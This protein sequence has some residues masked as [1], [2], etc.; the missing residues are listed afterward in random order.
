M[1]SRSHERRFLR[2]AVD[3]IWLERYAFVVLNKIDVRRL[4]AR[5]E[6]DRAPRVSAARR[7]AASMHKPCRLLWNVVLYDPVDVHNIQSARHH[8]GAHENCAFCPSKSFD[9]QASAQATIRHKT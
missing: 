5:E 9:L 4:F 3:G 6:D 2:E 1:R 8:I 7:S